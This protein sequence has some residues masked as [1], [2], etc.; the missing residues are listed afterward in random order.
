[1]VFVVGAYMDV[2]HREGRAS[3]VDGV[4]QQVAL[5]S[6]VLAISAEDLLGQ[7]RAADLDHLLGAALQADEVFAALVVGPAGTIVAGGAADLSCLPGELP[8]HLPVYEVNGRLDCGPGVRW[9]AT[10]LRPETGW[11]IVGLM[12]GVVSRG[13][14]ARCDTSCCCCARSGSQSRAHCR[15]GGLER[16][17]HAERPH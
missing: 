3:P 11:L 8:L 7:D 2:S 9:S 15:A 13:T 10:P 5:L 4:L 12:D 17:R 6:S 16:G 14:A 1:M